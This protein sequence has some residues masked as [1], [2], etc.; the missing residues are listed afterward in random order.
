[1]KIYIGIG[2]TPAQLIPTRVLKESIYQNRGN[3]ELVVDPI[4]EEPEYQSIA[5]LDDQ[6][7][8]TV[9]SLQRFLVAE[10]GAR[11]GCDL[12]FYIDSDIVCLGDFSTMVASYLRSD[13]VICVANPNPKF[14]QPVQSAVMLVKTSKTHQ[15]FLAE[16][17]NDY[18]E[19]RISYRDLMGSL[20]EEPIAHRVPHFFNSRDFVEANTVFLHYTDLWTQPWVSPYREEAVVWL[21]MHAKLME[22]DISYNELAKEG[23][24]LSYYRPGILESNSTWSWADLFFLPPQMKVYVKRRWFL[25]WIPDFLLGCAAQIVAFLR[26]AK[27][28]HTT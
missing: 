22:S 11:Y 21:R 10:I 15:R 13:R 14:D 12:S 6:S 7:V 18:L 19:R 8:G 25:R 5:S 23:V 2:T 3:F 27:K 28:V 24:T 16:I 1:M 26:A 9:F 17:L 20:C 4:Y